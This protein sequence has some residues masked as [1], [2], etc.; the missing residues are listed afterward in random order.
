SSPLADQ[1]DV[2]VGSPSEPSPGAAALLPATLMS[3]LAWHH[4]I[5]G[6]WSEIADRYVFDT[7]PLT[8]DRPYFA[9][10]VKTQDLPRV[11][12]RL[13]LLQDEGGY[14]LLWAPSPR[15]AFGALLLVGLPLAF[16]WRT[17]FY[18]FPGK[19]GTMLY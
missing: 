15:P 12:D 14:L 8:D 18:Q 4:L 17:I 5:R 2:A 6:D 10:Y 7:R 1:A 16:G 3:R 11:V 9:G 13:E 19:F